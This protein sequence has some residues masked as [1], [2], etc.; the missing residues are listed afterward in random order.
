[1][2]ICKDCE[3]FNQKSV[4]VGNGL[5][6]AAVCKHEECR[7]PINGDELFCQTARKEDVFCGIKARYYKKKEEE[8]RAKSE[9]GKVIQLV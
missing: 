1:M 6:L 8:A 2:K 5:A 9:D 3:Y 4:N 7:D